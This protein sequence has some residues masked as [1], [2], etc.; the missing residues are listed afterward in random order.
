MLVDAGPIGGPSAG[1]PAPNTGQSGNSS[2]G[3]S[4]GS[5]TGSLIA[6]RDYNNAYNEAQASAL[7]AFNAAE[8][9]KQ[10]KW[11]EKMSNTAHQR[12]VQDLIAAGLNPVLSAM[13]N[14]ASTPSG[15]QAS[16]SKATADTT[17]SEGLIS[18][19][20]AMIS[21][22]SAQ[23]IASMY[24]ENERYMAANYPTTK[25]GF[26]NTLLSGENSAGKIGSGLW[27]FGNNFWNGLKQRYNSWNH[28]GAKFQMPR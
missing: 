20:A 4:S 2:A 1:L 9:E 12:E 27:S 10:R 22:S 14:G 18:M 7:N 24:I 5:A 16:G 23:S 13:G 26:L 15:G 17:L 11:Q 19:M 25:F 28:S 21:A 8:A 6:S 3:S